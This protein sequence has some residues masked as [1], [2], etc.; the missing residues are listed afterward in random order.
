[1]LALLEALAEQLGIPVTYASLSTEEYGAR[2]GACLVRGDRRIIIER[3]LSGRQKAH[4][5]AEALAES[6]IDS[7]FLLPAVRE[8]I[9]DAR[10]SRHGHRAEPG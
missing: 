9:E 5:L 6:D 8:A 7:F 10:G 4:L 1:M 3:A 2:G